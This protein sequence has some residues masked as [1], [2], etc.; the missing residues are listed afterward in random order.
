VGDS[1][2]SSYTQANRL[3]SIS[4]PLGTDALLLQG[5]AGQEGISRLFTYELELLAYDNSAITFSSIVG[6]NVTITIQLPDGSSRYI[7]GYV[8]R[9]AQ[10]A[11]D[12]RYF[13]RYHAQLVPWLWFLTRQADCRIFQNMTAPDIITQV[14]GLFSFSTFQNNLTGSYPTLEYCVQYRETAFNFV[15]RLMEQFGIFY[16]FDHSTEGQH[17]LTMCD[18]NAGLQVC[19]GSPI[20]YQTKVGGLDD[21]E[22]ITD[23]RMEQE[24]ETGKYTVT[25]YNF[26]TPATSLLASEPTV[27]NVSPNSSLELFD[28]PGPHTILDDAQTVAKTRMQVEEAHSIVTTGSSNWR[29]LV[30]GYT[31]TLQNHYR[32]DQN[33]T[34]LATEVQ[35]VASEGNTY[36]T[37]I[38]ETES[39]SNRFTCIPTATPYRPNRVTRKPFVQGPQPALVVGKSGE[40]IWTDS[41][42]RVKVQFYWDRIGT[43]DENSSCWVR[44]SSPWAGSNWGA[45]S[46]PRIGQE[47]IVDFLEGDPDRPI[48]MGRVYNANQMPPYTLPDNQTRSTVQS[49]S[50][51]GGGAANFNELRFED[52]AGSEQIFLNAEKDMD[53]RVENDS[54]EYIGGSRHL[55]VAGSQFELV[56]TDK[57]GHVKGKH[58]EKI[59]S[60]KS[61]QVGGNC[62][63]SITGNHSVNISGDRK[64]SVTGN[65]SRSVTGDVKESVTGSVSLSVTGAQNESI[66][67]NFSRSVT[68][69]SNESVAQSVSQQIGESFNQQAGESVN[70]TAGMTINLTGGVS[71][72]IEGGGEGVSIVGPGGFISITEA[73]I[74]IMGTTVLINSGGSPGEAESAEC[75]SPSSPSSPDSP[76][77]PTAPT[78]PDTADDGSKGTKLS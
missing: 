62:M 65:D 72:N 18:S 34:Y 35:H 47:V 32:S 74:A 69:S 26:T 3:L 29:G 20:S 68:G 27:V 49:R 70:V 10:G 51:K 21:P 25:D 38:R 78:D 48:I 58:Y 60:D 11:T 76:D 73:G 40:E 13:T 43:D 50:S 67:S 57:H 41:Y 22:A 5:L 14:F 8:S 77:A 42:G 75:Q 37:G 56:D 71:V 4:T 36:V 64:E 54:R 1:D 59:E 7:N 9:F 30:S 28:Y 15:S 45:I 53:H 46:L 33:T 39:Y 44:V 24:L 61:L 2:S 16:Y 23:W 17:T 55:V 19:T 31:F 6:Q 52:L 66:T 12:E 63:E